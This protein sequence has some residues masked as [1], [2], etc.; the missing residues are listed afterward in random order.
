[1]AEADE[2]LRLQVLVNT[3]VRQAISELIGESREELI[4]RA[5]A[6]LIALGVSFDEKDLSAQLS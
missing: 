2:K 4:K 3:A 1:M 5:K 6:K